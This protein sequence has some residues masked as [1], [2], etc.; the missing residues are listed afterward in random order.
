M[1]EISRIK[2]VDDVYDVK[3]NE[4]QNMINILLSG[5]KENIVNENEELPPSK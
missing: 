3:D 1:P 4:L 5:Q 2:I